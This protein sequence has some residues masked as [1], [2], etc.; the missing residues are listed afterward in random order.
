MSGYT[1]APRAAFRPAT[2]A[3]HAGSVRAWAG[4]LW[5]KLVLMRRAAETRREL[6]SLNPRLLADIGVSRAEASREAERWPWDLEPERS[7]DR[8]TGAHW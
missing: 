6:G 1:S 7:R 2:G 3:A 4:A 8:G 5:A